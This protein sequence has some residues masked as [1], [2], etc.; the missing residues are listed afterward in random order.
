[1]IAQ[2]ICLCTQVVALRLRVQEDFRRDRE[3]L[4]VYG[5]FERLQAIFLTGAAEISHTGYSLQPDIMRRQ[6]RRS[7]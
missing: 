6:L 7:L 4:V 1:M 3:V 5:M 2:T